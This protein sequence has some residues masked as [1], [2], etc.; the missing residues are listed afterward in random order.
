[1]AQ[2]NGT[3]LGGWNVQTAVNQFG[4]ADYDGDGHAAMLVTSRHRGAP[5]GIDAHRGAVAAT[6]KGQLANR[7]AVALAGQL[8]TPVVEFPGDHGGFVTLPEQC[9]RILDQALT[10]TT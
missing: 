4:P 2:P 3:R 10:Q 8:G 6:S 9:G 5:G 7:R 1:M